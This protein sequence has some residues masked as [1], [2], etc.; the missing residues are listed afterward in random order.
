MQVNQNVFKFKFKFI[1]Q[2]SLES[3]L[4]VAKTYNR[5]KTNKCYMY[6]T[7]HKIKEQK[8]LRPH[9]HYIKFTVQKLNEY[10]VLPSYI[11]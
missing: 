5:H 3:I 9:E 10:S 11:L 4:Q 1:K 8:T 2:Q 7:V 6:N